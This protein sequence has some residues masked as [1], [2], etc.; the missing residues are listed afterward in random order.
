MTVVVKIVDMGLK[1]ALEHARALRQ[2]ALR[3][4]D[5]L[6]GFVRETSAQTDLGN[7]DSGD[8]ATAVQTSSLPKT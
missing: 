1:E 5:D 6:S 2:R 7:V 3:L 8:Y 4:S